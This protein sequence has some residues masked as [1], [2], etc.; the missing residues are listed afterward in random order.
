MYLRISGA[1]SDQLSFLVL[2]LGSL[3]SHFVGLNVHSRHSYCL[4]ISQLGASSN[5][6]Q[7]L[8]TNLYYFQSSSHQFVILEIGLIN[9]ASGAEYL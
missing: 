5:F 6:V 9:M 7:R 8:C 4:V 3:M 2:G 1:T